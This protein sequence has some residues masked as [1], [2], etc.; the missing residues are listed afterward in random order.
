MRCIYCGAEIKEGCI[1]CSACGKEAQIVPDYNEFE[2]DYINGLIGSETENDKLSREQQK[3]ARAEKKKKEELRAK[4]EQQKK[5]IIISAIVISLAVIILVIVLVSSIKNKQNNSFDY[6]VEQAEKAE[7][8][9]DT[10]KAVEYYERALTLDK[11]NIDVRYALADIYMDEKETDSAMILYKEIISLDKSQI[12]SYRQLISIYE[13]KEDYEAIAS[14]EE[15][16]SDAKILALFDDYIVTPP[17]FSLDGGTYDSEISVGLSVSSDSTVVYY[18]T[19]GKDPIQYGDV[20]DTDITF[21]EEGSYT[22][23]A[24]AKSDKGLYSDVVSERYKIEFKEPDLP[25]VNPDG[26]TFSA[27]TTVLVDVPAGCEAY[28]TWDS[29][30]PNIDSEKYAGGISVPVGNNVLSVVIY[31]PKT[32]KFSDVY[33]GRFVFYN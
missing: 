1:Y 5:I 32:E 9:D 12:D 27:E 22:I 8:D 25:V 17:V 13:S 28:Y 2:D 19:D 6:Q 3:K 4:R 14:L 29:S 26:G 11:D 21:D 33:K 7:K 31:N 20:F 16:V 18:T 23:K 30:D 15:N 10:A 24:V